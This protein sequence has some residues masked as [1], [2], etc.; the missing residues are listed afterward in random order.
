MKKFANKLLLFLLPFIMVTLFFEIY[1]RVVNTNY[2][3][4][5]NGLHA[6]QS[7]VELLILGNSHAN[8]GL[9]PDKFSVNAYNMAMVNQPLFYDFQILKKEIKNLKNLKYV[10]LSL[11]YHSLYFSS[12]GLR[13][14]WTYYDYQIDNNISLI[15]K[16]SRFWYG[17]TPKISL[18]M[19]KSDLYRRYYSYKHH[20]KTLNFYVEKDIDIT[21]TVKKGW[22]PYSKVN[23]KRL[24]PKSVLKKVQSFTQLTSKI[25]ERSKNI[26]LIKEIIAFNNS[27]NIKTIFVSLPCQKQF[28]KAID[29]KVRNK[30][31][32]ELNTIFKKSNVKYFDYFNYIND[33]SMFYD[34]DHL[35][36]KGANYIATVFNKDL[37]ETK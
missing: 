8:Y 37:F 29:T 35:N 13:D 1:L 2:K 28:V 34:S 24:K 26:E 27:H 16:I 9:N 6:N 5:I 18:S 21:D 32:F 30:D 25:K 3:E 11:D 22:L 12:Q 10:V 7:K 20:K 17:Y 19:L 33:T 36:K 15:N 23:Y 31:I 4:K 14:N